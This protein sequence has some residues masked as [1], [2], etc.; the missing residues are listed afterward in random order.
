MNNLLFGD[1]L[2]VQSRA[3]VLIV[4]VNHYKFTLDECYFC[5]YFYF[6]FYF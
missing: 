6:Y 2:L 4:S 1:C 5:L 3:K